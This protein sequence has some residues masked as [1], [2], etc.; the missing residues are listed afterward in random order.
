M[1]SAW[2]SD[3]A[4]YESPRVFFV[5]GTMYREKPHYGYDS[6][7]ESETEESDSGDGVGFRMKKDG[8]AQ[9]YDPIINNALG[10]SK[11]LSVEFE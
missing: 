4:R 2:D 6:P 11:G 3:W 8:G 10:D 7:G 1:S 5:G 9:R